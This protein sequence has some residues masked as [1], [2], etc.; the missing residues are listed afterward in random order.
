MTS[1]CRARFAATLPPRLPGL[2]DV[3]MEKLLNYP[4]RILL[5]APSETI[6]LIHDVT[7]ACLDDDD[8]V[9][10]N[11]RGGPERFTVTSW[12][13]IMDVQ[14]HHEGDYA[15]VASSLQGETEAVARVK[16]TENS[17]SS[18]IKQ[19]VL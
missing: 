4:V 18:H 19:Y 6:T 2:G 10:V 15:C 9:S 13:Q 11:M 7:S 5:I 8:H 14:K 12:L 17:K 1:F 16:V 3:L